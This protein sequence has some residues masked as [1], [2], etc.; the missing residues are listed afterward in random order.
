M[1]LKKIK[2]LFFKHTHTEKADQL[3][4]DDKYNY[5]E[6]VAIAFLNSLDEND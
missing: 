4:G 2:S 3:T 6:K 1:N 5:A